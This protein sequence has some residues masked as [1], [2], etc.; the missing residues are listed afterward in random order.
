MPLIGGFAAGEPILA[1]EHAECHYK[2]D[3]DLFKPHADFL[4]RVDGM[5]MKDIGIIDGD[6]LAVHRTTDVHNG[7]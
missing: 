3:P 5:S 4:L 1:T 6:T 7:K 2:V